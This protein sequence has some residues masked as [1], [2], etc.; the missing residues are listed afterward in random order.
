M[1]WL[2]IV[3][4]VIVGIPLLLVL[5]G[6]LLPRDHVARV[7][8]D[9]DAPP[10]RV[11]GLVSDVA[12]TPTW[13]KDV[14]AVTLEPSTGGSIRFTEKSKQ[15]EIPF[16]IVSQEPLR[17]QVVRIVDDKQPFGGTWT[18]ELE[19]AGAGTRLTITEDG[20]IK[21]PIFRVLSK[22]FFPPTATME[23]YLGDLSRGLTGG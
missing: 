20:F 5:I 10:E 6:S 21:N 14:T 4:A 7:T 12:A 13:R 18:W 9:L 11:W 17:R 8:R 19:P 3:L 16:E 1:R 2:W 22:L 23:K 15:G